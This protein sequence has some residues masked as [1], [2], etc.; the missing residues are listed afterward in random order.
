MT[1]PTA[2]L[3]E[4]SEINP[5]LGSVL[6]EGDEV[7]FLGMA[8]VSELGSTSL[9]ISRTYGE[10]KK[11]Y[12]AFADGDLL[13]A[14]ITPCF[15]NGKIAQ[16]QLEHPIGFGSTE[17]HVVRADEERADTRYL[18]HLIRG[19]EVRSAGQRR[20]TGS[21][22]QQRV[23][24]DF[25]RS[26]QIPLPPLTDQRRIAAILDQADELRTKRRHAL[27]L[28]DELADSAFEELQASS[29]ELASTHSLEEIGIWRSGGTPSRAVPE[30]F[31]GSIPW[32]T[33]GELN[34]MFIRTTK[35]LIS[36]TAV[37]ESAARYIPQGSLL[38]GMYDTA[39]LKSAIA[40][41]PMTC[42][43]AIAFGVLDKHKAL[44]EFVYFA[45]QAKRAEVLLLQ[46]GIRQKNL[47]LGIIKGITIQVPPLDVQREFLAV[48]EQINSLRLSYLVGLAHSDELFACL[49]HRAFRGEL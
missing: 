49:Q 14:K 5:R 34:S 33:S 31:A 4:I 16:A 21:G 6:G 10:V 9:G 22:G 12:T 27:T 45:V 13:F 48:I 30:Y 26:I 24:A 37:S 3:E 23:P 47:N 19:P 38:L 2:R 36:E 25:L 1:W 42:N 40:A 32:A 41:I 39:A 46:R 18:L 8:D 17:F 44:P 20:M 28:L 11:G 7:S 29:A 15:E 43:Q 35:E